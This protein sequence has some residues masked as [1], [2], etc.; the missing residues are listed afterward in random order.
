LKILTNLK[1]K[2]L[3][4]VSH[5]HIPYSLPH[6]NHS[7]SQIYEQNIIPLR[8]RLRDLPSSLYKRYHELYPPGS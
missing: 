8:E 2:S 3:L 5:F 7:F 1:L 4:I 6:S